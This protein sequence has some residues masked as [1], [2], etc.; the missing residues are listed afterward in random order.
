MNSTQR[1][2][3]MLSLVAAGLVV[4]AGRVEAQFPLSPT[5]WDENIS[6]TVGPSSTSFSGSD[7]AVPEP[8]TGELSGLGYDVAGSVGFGSAEPPVGTAQVDW[9]VSEGN[10]SLQL[11]S[12]VSIDFQCRVVETAPPPVGVTEVPVHLMA[13]GDVSADDV[14]GS[15]AT[16][17]F[18]FQAVGTAV[19]IT[20]NLDI[21]GDSETSDTFAIDETP[22]IPVDTIVLVGM[23]ASASMNTVSISAVETG[24]ATG[25]IDPVVEIADEIIPGTTSSYRDFFSIEFSEGYD[26]QTPVTR[27]TFGELKRRFG[28]LH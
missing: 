23:S 18:R 20:A 28:L 9:D 19:L 17:S 3:T 12:V 13:T 10:T 2:K 22:P 27:I 4:L 24:S 11:S 21:S 26:A 5:I 6:L 14:F 1:A 25:M 16:S 8:H 15:R 7:P